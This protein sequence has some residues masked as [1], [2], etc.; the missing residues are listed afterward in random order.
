MI[1]VEDGSILDIEPFTKYS[2]ILKVME[3]KA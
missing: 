3:K 2:L 1:D